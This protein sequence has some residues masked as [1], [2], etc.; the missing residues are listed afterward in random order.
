MAAETMSAIR[1]ERGTL[2]KPRST[3]A[4]TIYALGWVLWLVSLWMPGWPITIGVLGP[5]YVP[6]PVIFWLGALF[7]SMFTFGSDTATL[8]ARAALTVPYFLGLLAAVG[9]TALRGRPLRWIFRPVALGLLEA[10]L[11]AWSAYGD[12][13][14]KPEGKGYPLFAGFPAFAFASTLICMGAWLIPPRRA[15]ID[16]ENGTQR[17]ASNARRDS[18]VG[19]ALLA[20]GWVLWF[21]ALF[22]PGYHFAG[23]PAASL[24]MFGIL[25]TLFLMDCRSLFP[26]R[27]SPGLLWSVPYFLGLLAAIFRSASTRVRASRGFKV[28]LRILSIGLL[29]PLIRTAVTL[30]NP[31]SGIVFYGFF[32]LSAASALIFIGVWRF[33]PRQKRGTSTWENGKQSITSGTNPSS[34]TG[35][36]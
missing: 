35:E 28:L 3:I 25:R 34:G 8:L 20:V 24:R 12:S 31:P 4:W 22:F 10:W 21:F 32:A 13:L 9:G 33:P 29:A 23:A 1:S 19:A 16:G 5:R 26:F 15:K 18:L 7:A 6:A 36:T 27:F 11:Y 17:I 30:A 14:P 2:S